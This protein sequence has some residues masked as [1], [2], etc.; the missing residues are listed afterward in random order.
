MVFGGVPGGEEQGDCGEFPY[1]PGECCRRPGVFQFRQVPFPEFIPSAR[2]V[3]MVPCA[4]RGG[5]GH[6]LFP[7]V[8]VKR[9]L[10]DA[11]RPQPVDQYPVAVVGGFGFVNPF[12]AYACHGGNFSA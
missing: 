7:G 1:L 8:V 6:L 10:A 9:I 5:R 4:E 12:D 11:A 3:L 2:R